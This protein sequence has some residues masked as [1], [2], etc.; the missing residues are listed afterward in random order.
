[1]ASLSE[2]IPHL[3]KESYK[4]VEEASGILVLLDH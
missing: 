4:A 2:G 1:M 3:T